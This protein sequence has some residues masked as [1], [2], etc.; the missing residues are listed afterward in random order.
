MHTEADLR[1]LQNLIP[2]IFFRPV[3]LCVPGE[4]LRAV[5][6]MLL[7]ATHLPFVAA[8][9]AYE[10]FSPRYWWIADGE[11]NRD[12]L[13]YAESW[14]L[15]LNPESHSRTVSQA[16]PRIKSTQRQQH[17]IA[18]SSVSKSS[19]L[20]A[21]MSRSDISLVRHPTAGHNVSVA[22]AE[23]SEMRSLASI[24]EEVKELKQM[25]ANLSQLMSEL[26]PRFD[27]P[28]GAFGTEDELSVL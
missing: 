19:T 22:E 1:A 18:P 10:N 28:S 3:R 4:R 2:L 23:P 16:N 26:S 27:K 7:K 15:S 20:A 6:I 8:I 24:A 21:L 5:R 12:G 9:W 14:H 11:D 13:D 25:V 17:R